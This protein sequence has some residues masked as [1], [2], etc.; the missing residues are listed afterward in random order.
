MAYAPPR[1]LVG[2]DPRE[3]CRILNQLVRESVAQRRAGQCPSLARSG[4][5]YVREPKG[6]DIWLTA[7]ETFERGWGDSVLAGKRAEVG[8]KR[9][10]PGLS[11]AVAVVDGKMVLDPSRFL[12]MRGPG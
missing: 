5:R 10:R 3:A 4:V 12:G 2:G 8:I 11:H 1:S 7:R 6:Q 9:I